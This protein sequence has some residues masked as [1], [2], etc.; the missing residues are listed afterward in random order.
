MMKDMFSAPHLRGQPTVI[1]MAVLL[2]ILVLVVPLL[3]LILLVRV[4]DRHAH[5]HSQKRALALRF[6]GLDSLEVFLVSTVLLVTNLD[7]VMTN[8]GNQHCNHAI[9]NNEELMDRVGYSHMTHEKCVEETLRLGTGW[10]LLLAAVLF[11]NSAWRTSNGEAS[12]IVSAVVGLG[13]AIQGCWSRAAHALEGC[14][15][16]AVLVILRPEAA[17]VAVNIFLLLVGHLWLYMHVK[18]KADAPLN[19][20][21][22]VIAP[23]NFVAT[24]KRSM[25]AGAYL[26]AFAVALFVLAWPYA[27]LLSTFTV[28][29]WVRHKR[30]T[31]D[32]ALHVLEGMNVVAKWS[33]MEVFFFCL[34][35]VVTRMDSP[36][37]K[38]DVKVNRSRFFDLRVDAGS[39]SFDSF[40]ELLPGSMVMI[41]AIVLVTG[42][43]HWH[44]YELDPPQ[45]KQAAVKRTNSLP[46][47]V[48]TSGALLFLLLGV[49]QSVLLV[50]RKGFLG[51]A[52]GERSE[53]D[54]S[55]Y[56][57]LSMLT[58]QEFLKEQLTIQILSVM[59]AFLA[60]VAPT[61][62]MILLIAS[63][64]WLESH[65][66]LSCQ[67]RRIA[68]WLYSFDCVE[69]FLFTCIVI[70]H[71]FDSFISFVMKDEC[72]RLSGIMTHKNLDKVGL[73]YL[74]EKDCIKI[75]S[76]L[77]IGFWLFLVALVLRSI[78]WRMAHTPLQNKGS[79]VASAMLDSPGARL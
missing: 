41:C 65:A 61:L 75:E 34:T 48:A 11:R 70:L 59:A 44:V 24:V 18:I 25:Q 51:K 47:L 12:L 55:L 30:M 42:F 58:H 77:G 52:L 57:M 14:W 22:Q 79:E 31:K 4:A 73:L 8:E 27:K 68:E 67:V 40:I 38:L 6:Y 76:Q 43:T 26:M 64:H 74:Y 20:P 66:T 62:E 3:E 13:R 60:V 71:D 69:V 15:S 56:T 78:A 46:A 33:F 53:V 9:I 7:Q 35:A 45:P 50:D 72:Q 1:I 2:L 32:A 17:V 10:W 29:S 49:G 21:D 54:I 16:G 39:F 63:L 5:G 19:M 36:K 23:L 28:V 37:H